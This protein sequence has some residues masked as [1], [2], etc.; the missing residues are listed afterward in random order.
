MGPF[1]I[2]LIIV[3][4]LLFL[5]ISFGV[6]SVYFASYMVYSHTLMRRKGKNWGRQISEPGN[7]D[8]ETMWERGCAWAE[9]NKEFKKDVE[10]MSF[11][12]LKLVGEYYDFGNKDTVIIMPGRRECLMYSYFYA[13][14]YRN[15]GVNVL[16][17]DQRAHG[18]SE[19]TYS[20]CGI[21]EGK[22]VIEWCNYLHDIHGQEGIFLHG[23]CVGSCCSTNTIR[24]ERCP[25]FIKGIIFD[26][27]FINYKEIYG[28]HM[29]ELGHKLGIVWRFIWKWFTH[30]TGCDIDDSAPL[31][32]MD[33]VTL[34]SCFIWGKKDVYCIPE[35]SELIW[36]KCT[37][38]NK[39]RHWFE[40]GTHSKLRLHDSNKYDEIVSNFI[41]KYK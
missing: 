5:G 35:K 16:V 29:L 28:N 13:A 41:R 11:D 38:E 14:P 40:D 36:E 25:K 26:S 34:P 32:Y 7:A 39:E 27:A 9:E 4:V 18:L 2:I 6:F 30:F 1:E 33:K 22:D 37:S 10:V 24:D 23:V 19:G 3:G 12:G 20:T 15:V 17:I 8:L 21:L 31:K